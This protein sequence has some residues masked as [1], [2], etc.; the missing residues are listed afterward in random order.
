MKNKPDNKMKM[1]GPVHLSLVHVN[2]RRTNG[3]S[4]IIPLLNVSREY[5]GAEFIFAKIYEHD[6]GDIIM[7]TMDDYCITELTLNTYVIPAMHNFWK[8][9]NEMSKVNPSAFNG[10]KRICGFVASLCSFGKC[11]K[12]QGGKHP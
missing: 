3:K 10:K 5:Q 1:R 9:V 4:T 12:C 2:L 8:I 7:R 6:C 11:S